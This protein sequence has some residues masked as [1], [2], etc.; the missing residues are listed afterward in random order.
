MSSHPA[1]H[2]NHSLSI[3]EERREGES[4]SQSKL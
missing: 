1:V 3:S 2:G 4:N